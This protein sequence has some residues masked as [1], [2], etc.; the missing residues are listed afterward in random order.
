MDA[1][2]QGSLCASMHQLQDKLQDKL[3]VQIEPTNKPKQLLDDLAVL[4]LLSPS[5]LALPTIHAFRSLSLD[6]LARCIRICD[7]NAD[8]SFSIL[9]SLLSIDSVKTCESR[10]QCC[11]SNSEVKQIALLHVIAKSSPFVSLEAKSLVIKAIDV[12]N[13]S[14]TQSL[15]KP[16]L[17]VLKSL[18][19]LLSWDKMLVG[20]FFVRYGWNL[21]IYRWVMDRKDVSCEALGYAARIVSLLFGLSDAQQSNLFRSLSSDNHFSKLLLIP[22]EDLSEYE[23]GHSLLFDCTADIKEAKGS[24]VVTEHDLCPWI[25]SVCGILMLHKDFQSTLT[26]S[27]LAQC[28]TVQMAKHLSQMAL[29]VS[30]GM[31]VLL[32]GPPG[33]GKTHLVEEL[34]RRLDSQQLYTVHLGDQTDSKM[35]LGTYVT[36]STPGS[37]KWM[38]GVLTNAVTQGRWVLIEDIDLAPMDVM[39]ILVPL[40]ETR[41]LHIPS[42]GERIKAKNGFH[43]F[44]TRSSSKQHLG[45]NLWF[46]LTIDHLDLLQTQ[47]IVQY[48]FHRL[49]SVLPCVLA[50]YET[51]AGCLASIHS[52]RTL[53]LRDLIKWCLRAETQLSSHSSAP[54][55]DSIKEVLLREALDCFLGMVPNNDARSALALK[56]G[57]ALDISSHRIEFFLHHHVPQV[58]FGSQNGEFAVC[59][60]ASLVSNSI[61]DIQKHVFASTSRSLRLLESVAVCVLLNEPVL[62]C[63]ETGTGKTTV[64]QHLASK[65]GNKLIVVNMSQQ[66]DSTD[67]L[68]GFKPV[69]ALM[70][71]SQLKEVFEDLFS[72]TFSVKNNVSFLESIQKAFRRRQWKQLLIGFRNAVVLAEKLITKTSSAS[73]IDSDNQ[74]PK[75]KKQRHMDPQLQAAWEAFKSQ[76]SQFEAQLE[77]IKQKFLFSFVEG[78]LVKAIRL[79]YWVL[80][81]EINLATAETLECLGGLLQ[82]PDGSILLLERGDT[83]AVKR[84]SNFRL[85]ACMNPAN[86]AGKRDLAA[87]L[88]SRFTEFWVD[89]PD[90]TQHDLIMIIRS[91][92][93][94]YLPPGSAGD[95]ICCDVAGFYQAAKS[96]A[97]DGLLFD[98]A[99]QPFHISMRTLTRAL[100]Y[101]VQIAPVYGIKRALYE[102]TYMMFLTGLGN[103]S[104]EKLLS[105]LFK[106]VLNGVSN[107]SAFIKQIPKHP[108]ASEYSSA[109]NEEF[110][111]EQALAESPFTLV[112]C[113]WIEKSDLP[114]PEDLNTQFVL[115]PSVEANLRNLGRAVLSRKYPVLIQGPTS[116]GKTSMVQYLANLTGHRFLRINNHEH[117]DIQEYIGGYVSNDEGALVFQDGVLVEAL[118]KG[119][120]IVLD[121]LNLAPTDVLEALNR[122]LDDNRELF[123]PETQETIKPHPHFMLF[124]TQNPAGQYGGRKKLSRAFRNR[125]LEL[126]FSDIP[127][128]ELTTILER[129]CRIAPSY[130]K[131]LVSVFNR[132]QKMRDTSHIFEGR[133]SF[134]TLRDLFR[135]A[136]RGADSYQ[137]LGEDGYMLLAERVRKHDDRLVIKKIIQEEMRIKICPDQLYDSLFESLWAEVHNGVSMRQRVTAE[138]GV[139]WT[140]AM[141]RLFVLVSHCAKFKEPLLLVGET[142][143]GKTTVCQVLA[144]LLNRS[145]HMVNAHQNSETA[146]FLGG[147]RPIRGRNDTQSMFK[148]E[149]ASLVGKSAKDVTTENLMDALSAELAS[150]NVSI[151]SD[152]EIRRSRIEAC[153]KLG[154]KSRALFEWHDGPL[155]QAMKQGHLFLLDEISLAD[156]SV[157]ERLNSVLEPQR[158]LVLAERGSKDV[159]EITAVDEFLFFA[160]MNPGGDYG[161][162]ELS[163]ALRN[164]FTEIWV[165]S[166][167]N[168]D[169]LRMIISRKLESVDCE[170]TEESNWCNE[171]ADRILDFL[172]WLATQLN[173]PIDAVI[174]LRD[175]LAWVKF[176]QTTVRKLGLKQAFF[177]G[178]C[179]IVVDGMSINP[180]FGHF[181]PTNELRIQAI[182]LLKQLSGI[183]S[184]S[185]ALQSATRLSNNASECSRELSEFLDGSNRQIQLF[186]NCRFGSE[187]FYILTGPLS[188]KN[189]PFALEAPTTY[190]NAM[191]IMRAMQLQ[192]PILLEGSPGVGKTSI[193]STLGAV[194]GH[195]LVRINLSEQT[196]LMD[197]FGSDL[198]VEGGEGGEFCWR[199]GPFLKAMQDGDWVLLDELNLASQQVLEGL[200][201]CLDHRSSLYIPELDKTVVCHPHFRVFAAQNPQN[202]GGGRKGLPKSFVNRFTQVYV[203]P[204]TEGDLLFICLALYPVIPKVVCEKMI[205]FNESL[206]REIMVQGTFGWTGSPWEFNLRDVLRW[207]ELWNTNHVEN[208]VNEIQET[209]QQIGMYF[210]MLYSQ[211]MRTKGDRERVRD[212]FQQVFGFLPERSTN[213][214]EYTIHPEIV[215]FG[216]VSLKRAS[217]RHNHKYGVPTSQ[218]QF[219]PS[220]SSIM[221]SLIMCIQTRSLPL[222]VGRTGSGKSS[223]VRLLASMTGQKLEELS[224]NPGVDALELLGCFEQVDLKRLLQE[225]VD[226]TELWVENVLIMHLLETGHQSVDLDTINRLHEGWTRFAKGNDGDMSVEDT[227]D[228]ILAVLA[229]LDSISA[230]LHEF[231]DIRQELHSKVSHLKR[232]MRSG[233]QGQFE[234][235]DS[236]LVR[237]LEFGHWILIDNINL[238]PSSVLDRLNPLLEVNGSI[239]ISERG[240]VNGEIKTIKPHKNFRLFMAM[241]PVHGEVS[242][243]MRNRSVELFIDDCESE[244]C[245]KVLE[246]SKLLSSAGLPVNSVANA[247]VTSEDHKELVDARFCMIGSRIAVEC[248]QR[249]FSMRKSLSTA[250]GDNIAD[251]VSTSH[252]D[253][254]IATPICCFWPQMVSADLYISE[255]TLASVALSASSIVINSLTSTYTFLAPMAENAL[256]V[257][258]P[259][260]KHLLRAATDIFIEQNSVTD[261]SQRIKWLSFWIGNIENS[262]D[263]DLKLVLDGCKH[264]LS[265]GNRTS[266]EYCIEYQKFVDK[267]HYEGASRTTLKNMSVAQLSYLANTGKLDVSSLPHAAI[268]T[269]F[270]LLTIMHQACT[271]LLSIKRDSNDIH[272]IERILE[273][274]EC[275]WIA[276]TTNNMD[277][278]KL[279]VCVKRATKALLKLHGRLPDDKTMNQLMTICRSVNDHLRMDKVKALNSLSKY[280]GIITLRDARLVSILNGF[281][282]VNDMLSPS[283]R[284]VEQWILQNQAYHEVKQYIVE[285]VSTLYYLNEQVSLVEDLIA[286]VESV[287]K[288]LR[289][290]IDDRRLLEPLSLASLASL[291]TNVFSSLLWPI[292]DTW[293]LAQEQEIISSAF[294][295]V[296]TDSQPSK[297]IVSNIRLY[298][299]D[300]LA[301]GSFESL[302]Y[303]P[304]QRLQWYLDEESHVHTVSNASIRE[305]SFTMLQDMLFNWF[306][307]FSINGS[308]ALLAMDEI[309]MNH[310]LDG[311]IESLLEVSSM[312]VDNRTKKQTYSAMLSSLSLH[313][314][315]I[316]KHSSS[317]PLLAANHKSVQLQNIANHLASSRFEMQSIK[318]DA[319]ILI[320]C[321]QQ[322]LVVFCNNDPQTVT[323]ATE[324]LKSLLEGPG[325]A[326]TR[327]KLVGKLFGTTRDHVLKRFIVPLIQELSNSTEIPVHGLG[328]AWVLYALAFLDVFLPNVAVDPVEMRTAKV[329]LAEHQNNTIKANILIRSE[330][331]FFIYGKT[332]Q[333]LFESQFECLERNASRIFKWKAKLP[334]R[335]PKSEMASI[336]QDLQTIKQQILD[337]DSVQKLCD[338]LSV[339]DSRAIDE[340]WSLQ[341]V[342]ASFAQRME[343]K[344]PM[345]QDIL[346]PILTAIYQLKYGLRLVRHDSSQNTNHNTFNQTIQSVL[347]KPIQQLST[348]SLTTV[349]PFLG[350]QARTQSV[351]ALQQTFSALL[352]ISLKLQSSFTSIKACKEQDFALL[353]LLFDTMTEMW[354]EADRKRQEQQQAE[355]NL[356]KPVSVNIQSDDEL[357]A[358]ELKKRFPDFFEV[359]GDIAE[360]QDDSHDEQR[361]V[362][363]STQKVASIDS[364]TIWEIV[365]AFDNIVAALDGT[366]KT[367]FNDA[368]NKSCNI[369]LSASYYLMSRYN[370]TAPEMSRDSEKE[371]RLGLLF[372]TCRQIECW[373]NES[374]SEQEDYDF[375]K[376][377]NVFEAKQ[378]LPLL[379]K[380]DERIS[381][382]LDQWPDHDVIMSLRAICRRIASFP[383]ESPLMK[384]LTGLELLLTKSQDW[385][386][387]ASRQVSLRDCMNALTAYI[388]RWRKLEL[389]TWRQLLTLE[390][391]RCAS[392]A[393]SIWFHLWRSIMG[394]VRNPEANE[395]L[396]NSLF[397]VID[398]VMVNS[399]ISQFRARL[400]MLQVFWRHLV[401]LG[402]QMASRDAD[403]SKK[404]LDTVGSILG[405]IAGFYS[406]F[407]ESIEKALDDAKK[408]ILKE[409]KGYVKVATWKDVNVFALKESAR[410]THYHLGKFIKLYRVAL[411]S[412]AKNVMLSYQSIVPSLPQCKTTIC[413]ALR[414]LI[415]THAKEF[416]PNVSMPTID[417]NAQSHLK[418]LSDGEKLFDRMK[419]LTNQVV[420]DN[421]FLPASLGIQELTQ[422]VVD[423]VKEYRESNADIQKDAKA[424]KG[425]RMLRK[426]GLVDLLKQLAYLGLSS[427]CVQT[428]ASQQEMSFVARIPIIEPDIISRMW[429]KMNPRDATSGMWL[430]RELES[431]L[432][433]LNQYHYRMMS[434]MSVMRAATLS[435]SPDLSRA[436]V[437][438]GSSFMEHLMHLSLE[439]RRWLHFHFNRLEQLSIFM[440]QLNALHSRQSTSEADEIVVVASISNSIDKMKTAIDG[441]VLVFSQ[442]QNVLATCRKQVAVDADLVTLFDGLNNLL[443]QQRKRVEEAHKTYGNPLVLNGVT[444]RS[445]VEGLSLNDVH[446]QLVLISDEL[447]RFTGL[448]PAQQAFLENALSAIEST[449]KATS[450]LVVPTKDDETQCS[451]VSTVLEKAECVIENLLIA[452]QHL[453]STSV[454]EAS[455]DEKDS[456]G[457]IPNN[458]LI[459]FKLNNDIFDHGIMNKLFSSLS[460]LMAS[461]QQAYPPSKTNHT[462][463]IRLMCRLYPMLNQFFMLSRLRIAQQVSYQKQVAKMSYILTN[464]FVSLFTDGFGLPKTEGDEEDDAEGDGETKDGMGIGEGDG[465]KDV[466]SEMETEDQIEGLQNDTQ[467]Q[468]PP[469]KQ[470]MKD[471]EDGIEMSNDFDGVLEDVSEDENDDKEDEDDGKED[472]DV[473]EQMGQLDKDMADVVDEKLW[474]DDDASDQQK[475]NDEKQERDASVNAG[476]NETETIA[477]ETEQESNGEEHKSTEKQQER[478]VKPQ[479]DEPEED[480]NDAEAINTD[481]AFE[482]KHDVDVKDGNDLDDN[483]DSK[484]EDIPDNLE[485]ESLDGD[486]E[487]D[488]GSDSKKQSEQVIDE[489]T[490]DVEMEGEL[491]IADEVDDVEM[492]EADEPNDATDEENP[493]DATDEEKPLDS[494]DEEKPLDSTDEEA[495]LVNEQ[496]GGENP[497]EQQQEEEKEASFENINSSS[498]ESNQQFGVQA[499]DQGDDAIQG[500]SNAQ[501]QNDAEGA[502]DAPNADSH[503]NE[504]KQK[505]EDIATDKQ[506]MTSK[507]RKDHIDANPHRSLGDAMKQWLSRI[508]QI[509]ESTSESQS[510][511]QPTNEEM[512]V[513]GD[514]Q[515]EFITNKEEQ[516]DKVNQQAL[517]DATEDQLDRMDRQ[518]IADEE[519]MGDYQQQSDDD[520]IESMTNDV[521]PEITSK[522][523]RL[524]QAVTN[525]SQ[526]DQKTV[527]DASSSDSSDSEMD[528]SHEIV[529]RHNGQ[530]EMSRSKSRLSAK[531]DDVNPATSDDEESETVDYETLRRDLEQRM[532][533]LRQDKSGL[534]ASDDAALKKMWS[535]YVML[536]RELSFHL[537][538]QLRLI[539]EPTLATKLKGDYRTGKRLNMRKVVSYVAS[540]FKKDKIW[541]RRAKPSKRTYQVLVCVDDS[542]SMAESHSAQLAFESLA[543]ISKALAQLEVGEMGIARFGEMLELVHA[544]DQPFT[545]ASGVD[546]IRSFT[547]SQDNTHVRRMM[548]TSLALML[549]A[550]CNQ[551]Q[552]NG[553]IW[554]LQLV[555]SDGICQDHEMV[556]ALVRQAAEKHLMVVFLVLDNRPE[557]DSIVNMANVSYDVDAATGRSVL[558]IDRYMDTFPFDYHVI[559][560]NIEKL[561]SVLAE[562]LRQFFTFASAL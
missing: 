175:V 215:T 396:M 168:R 14:V 114:I 372:A 226:E 414:D 171:W 176:I 98:G 435:L 412:P 505:S 252:N 165:P 286:V 423:R 534:K 151:Q 131:K 207:I 391:R 392:A 316:L 41:W 502:E 321:L 219:L 247:L 476:T 233:V 153:L 270:P 337:T 33:C 43:V 163:P 330:Q 562:T 174:S 381:A 552:T 363:V 340:E 1:F 181:G 522:Q 517:G 408:P 62:L 161:K 218:L 31:P 475:S 315:T 13:P 8:L 178:G 540:Q 244:A 182:L 35:L 106:H 142:G 528:E 68:G 554:Q 220:H 545:D 256:L 84:H 291:C 525:Q 530:T 283:N 63:G 431:L 362:S 238:C 285:G 289:Q 253:T 409:L 133:Q 225:I 448:Y 419:K 420:E 88:R 488:E 379:C 214:P 125:F 305:F 506:P 198:P 432:T 140:S 19:K 343:K 445:I 498:K 3:Q 29:G 263:A 441:A 436:E 148:Q 89:S 127:E 137:K 446:K 45:E 454:S 504:S 376:D 274:R 108:Q 328:K 470:H 479:T 141:R 61:R 356:Y 17:N 228:N 27:T 312:D 245:T 443:L 119:Y 186:D 48:R 489:E 459:N 556:R 348:E 434:R 302:H 195:S 360:R 521:K 177:H 232:L 292:Y 537:C 146:D 386:A 144:T 320:A 116:A 280:T 135:W 342:L 65:T 201:A 4:M 444:C 87:G 75:R 78:T 339:S 236:A 519:K 478:D 249:G 2:M 295:F 468:Q 323:E 463:L 208:G 500:E 276:V 85:F 255:S 73:Q 401:V 494:T 123:I 92:L 100:S 361:Q 90:A 544:F 385:E 250:F 425:Q 365:K 483:Q 457:F 298:M 557:K 18:Y 538:E 54:S 485:L 234:W 338:K 394:V 22:L 350:D 222:I 513:T 50:A 344:Y 333:D 279:V 70:L 484:E 492:E 549:Q 204:L 74:G 359:F 288:Q 464:L 23:K 390:E 374:V 129:R 542:R 231:D 224:L 36:T 160:T 246:S 212:L 539:L 429:S 105:I 183:I 134:V 427:R 150:I 541:L 341:D 69:D 139:V 77:H 529:P 438:K 380:F 382:L 318:N 81:D 145:L 16:D 442:T 551:S 413:E 101:A 59:G 351:D 120:W 313:H 450:V 373:N 411:E 453:R 317:T 46:R 223:M 368:W 102:G 357:D 281:K 472:E 93:F 282:E 387:Y 514:E 518:A 57:E 490:K 132:L 259:E 190:M 241:D 6:L 422:T 325:T 94:D 527:D 136:L 471:E 272:L 516:R 486:N 130:A 462:L 147:Q 206:R 535:S 113:F 191:R 55:P 26:S 332:S 319:Q 296:C 58:N 466:S 221:E 430:N 21:S 210:E 117:T 40:L 254:G 25:V 170:S 159:E 403:T 533:L 67:L 97:V 481:N 355:E 406:Q 480:E 456:F 303:E 482:D 179:M 367:S 496:H 349:V 550:R 11:C 38:P 491:E 474:N 167:S 308:V 86:D 229:Q 180:L 440:V 122:L 15:A 154:Q 71:A 526:D 265:L 273:T 188:P 79:G 377:P 543:M 109:G 561:P 469:E 104:S 555:I 512:D 47:D 5:C 103:E 375:Y 158:L 301:R 156:D 96:L 306:K 487:M 452:F 95:R 493:L 121:E 28:T 558:K 331:Q 358:L 369:G 34:S 353:H 44:A 51:V 495:I 532:T 547:F 72:R 277:L 402:S 128:H 196:D 267:R 262:I 378:I 243:A 217:N 10:N 99:D 189:I 60:R 304:F 428:Y 138:H 173:K 461:L 520:E 205:Q 111:Y 465:K 152:G 12:F 216:N 211:R 389:Q 347:L 271:L 192:K 346:Q 30:L 393:G 437:E 352:T 185:E 187:P 260:Q 169:D 230:S 467:Q 82:S 395:D 510:Y 509:S 546:V 311:Q 370:E 42:R 287:P 458:L 112:D 200:N 439:Q 388:I 523:S 400:N 314:L 300:A 124:A 366:P 209:E 126:H 410:R 91:Y 9:P 258:R 503:N 184:P 418:R 202:E 284:K 115:T 477:K 404:T 336:V 508:K 384:F 307:G 56:L 511:E 194:S 199:D 455:E 164:R 417:S 329:Q 203:S 335:P 157:L 499:E 327:E 531:V 451:D 197:L 324:L 524:T 433:R 397:A 407:N 398:D 559:V 162:K 172:Y 268:P 32:Q 248:L 155:L 515:F 299:K 294:D 497:Q 107:P 240:L 507:R 416:V 310:L 415:Q 553:D 354:Y 548:E 290:N 449:V 237:A 426:K 83:Q 227:F 322:L 39:A 266:V 424:V 460:D 334:I 278:C 20:P 264:V 447:K 143:C 110:D 309:P 293:I 7:S 76:V 166:I 399:N 66:S 149:A 364:N 261:I 49:T 275:L 405:N 536:T 37:F 235:V 501:V 251:I 257:E 242:R 421:I 53:C 297:D 52:C 326:E 239:S 371:T 118:R 383:V 213:L 473:D 269:V 24:I 193:V 560:R 80:L 345:Y 64:V